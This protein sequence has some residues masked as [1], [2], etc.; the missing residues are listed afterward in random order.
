[1]SSGKRMYKC[2]EEIISILVMTNK[3]NGNV[4][5]PKNDAIGGSHGQ[6]GGC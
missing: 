2:E 5:M 6:G 1:M 3:E 4:S